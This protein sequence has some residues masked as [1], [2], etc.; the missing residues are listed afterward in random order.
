MTRRRL[1]GT[2]G[3]KQ[4]CYVLSARASVYESV[5]AAQRI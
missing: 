1:L 4:L 5:L 2:E 3:I